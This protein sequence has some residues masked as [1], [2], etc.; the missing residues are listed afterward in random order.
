MNCNINKEIIIN[1][2]YMN[3]LSKTKFCK[4]CGISLQILNKIL[5][6]KTN[7]N[8]SSLYKICKVLKI[9]LYQ[10]FI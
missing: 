9:K 2:M 10:I 3:H 5:S 8:I 6:D 1:Y 7:F 4:I